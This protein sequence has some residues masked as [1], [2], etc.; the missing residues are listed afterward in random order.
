ML[1]KIHSKMITCKFP[2]CILQGG[3]AVEYARKFFLCIF[4]VSL[5]GFETIIEK[6]DGK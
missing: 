6:A 3:D 2:D 1:N 5:P 4:N